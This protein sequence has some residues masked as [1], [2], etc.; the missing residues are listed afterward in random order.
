VYPESET[1]DMTIRARCNNYQASAGNV[2]VK[3]TYV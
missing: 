2:T 3:L 1:Q